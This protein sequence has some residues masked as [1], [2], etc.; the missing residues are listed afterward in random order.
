[1]IEDLEKIKG[2]MHR[3]RK[4]NKEIKSCLDSCDGNRDHARGNYFN[5]E[6]LE[7]ERKKLETILL[8]HI[9]D[10]FL[11]TQIQQL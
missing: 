10:N 4:A 2:Y 6:Q 5:L 11:I 7:H 9:P 8:V 1:M 3:H